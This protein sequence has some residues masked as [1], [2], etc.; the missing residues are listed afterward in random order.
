LLKNV[1]RGSIQKVA[2]GPEFSKNISEEDSYNAMLTILDNDADPVQA[3]IY[4]IA[5]RMK[6]ET[7]DEN[8]GSLK[9]LI[10]KSNIITADVNELL[11]VAE[12]YNGFVRNTPLSAFLPAVFSAIGI[13]CVTHGVETVGPKFGLTTKKILKTSGIN[14]NKSMEEASNSL[15]NKDIGWA[16]IDQE[17]F[18]KPLYDLIEL[19]T[20]MVK[21]TILT[22][23]EVLVGPIRAKNKTHLLTGYVHTAYPPIYSSLAKVSGFDSVVLVKGVE[24]GVSPALRGDGKVFYYLDNKEM[25]EIK[26]NPKTIS[27]EQNMR[28]VPLPDL[29]KQEEIKLDEI[30]SDINV[31][32]FSTKA[33]EIGNEALNGK[34]GPAKDTLIYTGAL[35]LSIIKNIDFNEAASQIKKAIDSGKAKDFFYNAI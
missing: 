29:E 7:I 5:M 15:S 30:S 9:A 35:T 12:P 19:R 22:T 4:L 3:A 2:T 1:L 13:P 14:V 34:D 20:R 23:I 27:I 26:F 8:I 31:E 21:R 24:G 28:A 33:S 25:Q 17:K 11:D 10:D 16:Y 18:C 32:A 6:R